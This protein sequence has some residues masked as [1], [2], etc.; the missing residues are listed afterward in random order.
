ACTPEPIATD[1]RPMRSTPNGSTTSPY[2]CRTT[3]GSAEQRPYPY[4][5]GCNA[6]P[7]A[8]P[9]YVTQGRVRLGLF[10]LTLVPLFGDGETPYVPLS[11]KSTPSSASNDVT[12][13][14]V[15]RQSSAASRRRRCSIQPTRRCV[16][17]LRTTGLTKN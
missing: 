3:R 14:T 10:V 1:C 11:P 13:F 9:T 4:P 2:A 15:S 17:L 6:S 16:S 8:P 12:I 5:D 7:P